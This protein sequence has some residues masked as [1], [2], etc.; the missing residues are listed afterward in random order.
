MKIKNI[1][2]AFFVMFA[3]V[4]HAQTEAFPD[5]AK[6]LYAELETKDGVVTLALFPDVAPLTVAA[7]VDRVNEGF[8]DG[9]FF[10]RVI[11]GFVAQGGDPSLIGKKPA[12]YT[13]P[14][15]FTTRLKHRKGTLAMARLG[16]DIHSASTQFYIAYG[17]QPHLDGQ[18]TIFGEVVRGMDAVDKVKQGDKML[19]VRMVSKPQ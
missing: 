9:M 6:T 7:F 5:P 4:A 14:A 10:H 13:L 18:Y 17:N 8:Y 12:G 19:K 3:S 11:P 16:N 1:L 2:L 15:E